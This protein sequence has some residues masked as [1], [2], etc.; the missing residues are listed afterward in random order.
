MLGDNWIIPE[1]DKKAEENLSKSLCVYPLTSRILLSRGFSA[2]DAAKSYL[3]KSN[4][5][6]HSPLLMKDM[7]KARDRIKRA[8]KD[9]EHIC[10]YGDYDVDGVT[11]TAMLYLYL[12]SE[13]ASCECF[14]PER[15]SEGYG[16]NK[17]SIEKIAIAATLIITVDTGITAVDEVAFAAALGVDVIITD[18][19]NCR[20]TPRRL[21]PL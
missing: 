3:N 12:K 13:G 16:L 15:L 7:E 8:I 1:I 21:T 4:L 5:T 17:S 11:S 6:L 18:H 14:I 20:E 10:I 19:H 2:P 9:G